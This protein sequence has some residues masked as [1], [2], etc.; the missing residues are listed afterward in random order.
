MTLEKVVEKLSHNPAIL[1]GIDRRGFIR[2]GYYADLVIIN[3]DKK[4]YV[5]NENVLYKCGWTPYN[6]I[7]LSN[8]VD[9]TFVNGSLVYHDGIIED[10][11]NAKRLIFN[12]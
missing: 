4:Q 7:V 2:E 5:N 12:R 3:P 10:I 8:S 1:F 11:I 6:G 9:S